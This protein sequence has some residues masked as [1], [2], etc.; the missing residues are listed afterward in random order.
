MDEKSRTQNRVDQRFKLGAA[1]VWA[2]PDQSEP[3]WQAAAAEGRSLLGVAAGWRRRT[4]GG[5][6]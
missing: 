4:T 1:A 3:C 6:L 2:Q 5:F